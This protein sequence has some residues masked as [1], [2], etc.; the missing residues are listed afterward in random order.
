MNIVQQWKMLPEDLRGLLIPIKNQEQ[1]QKALLLVKELM[2]K[3]VASQLD[4][5]E[6]ELYSI[7]RSN[8]L[9]YDNENV[10][11]DGKLE[12]LEILK[13]IIEI[14]KLKQ[15]DLKD[16]FGSQSIVSDILSGKRKIN[17]KQ[18]KCLGERFHLNPQIFLT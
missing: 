16:C 7:V 15:V 6:R 5:S 14:H 8:L 12:P 13:N 3:S 17:F 11:I 9:D 1:Y 4:E 18:A 10:K 2:T